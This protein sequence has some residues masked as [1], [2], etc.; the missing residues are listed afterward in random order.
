MPDC[1]QIPTVS[2]GLGPIQAIYQAQFSKYLEHRGL[3]PKSDRK[4]WCFLG[5]GETDEPESLG[6]IALAGHEGLDNLIFVI[7]FNLQRLDGPCASNG[8]IIQELE[9]VFRGAGWNAIKVIWGSQWDALLARDVSGELHQR[10]MEARS[11][12]SIRRTKPSAVRTPA[13]T[14]SA[15]TRRPR[16]S[17]PT[18]RTMTSRT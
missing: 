10:M 13:S 15:S 7:S 6:A 17:L 16:H 4:I 11:M 2:M 12:A 9:G 8:K 14:F 18:S 1:W 5:D 3:M